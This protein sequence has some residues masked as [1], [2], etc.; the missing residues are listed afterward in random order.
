VSRRA[1]CSVAAV[2][3]A[4]L[5]GLLFAVPAN[6]VVLGPGPS[7]NTVGDG[8]ARCPS[9]VGDG[10][11]PLISVPAADDHPSTSTLA[12]MTVSQ[13]D[14]RPSIGQALFDSVRPGH[15]VVPREEIYPPGTSTGQVSQQDRS[16]MVQAQDV[17]VVAAEGVL[18]LDRTTVVEV[19]P[20]PATG[21]L[22]KGDILESVDGVTLASAADFVTDTTGTSTTTT[23]T[24]G[25][26]RN[27]VRSTVQLHKGQLGTGKNKQ[28]LFGIKVTDMPTIPVSITL[29]PNAIGGPSAGMMFALGVYDRLTPGSLT[30]GVVVA[31]TG[32]LS[33]DAGDVVPI[34]GIQQ[35]LYAARHDV[36]AT[37]FLAPQGNCSDTRGAIPAGL[38]VVP[39]STLRQALSVL[40]QVRAGRTAD[41]P[42]C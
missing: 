28:A 30:G 7:C 9:T 2:A 1:A 20:G 31:G 19:E 22:Q 17:A 41:L 25:I 37:L 13:D 36:H 29:D 34:G 11:G 38:Q 3:V 6:Y 14:G 26:D 5:V 10:R 24:V 15:A 21:V 4:V 32:Q 42:H 40:A 16:D 39:V 33:D 27:G 23:Y 8:A 12:F 35:K 18:G